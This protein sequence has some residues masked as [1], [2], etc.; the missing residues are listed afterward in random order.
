[1]QEI[2]VCFILRASDARIGYQ[3]N[4][5]TI[6]N[7]RYKKSIKVLKLWID[8]TWNTE[9]GII[10][11]NMIYIIGY[12]L[13]TKNLLL[14]FRARRQVRVKVHR[15]VARW[16]EERWQPGPALRDWAKMLQVN[17]TRAQ[18]TPR[19]LIWCE[20]LSCEQ[21]TTITTSTTWT[22]IT[23]AE[24]PT[25]TITRWAR[26]M[27]DQVHYNKIV[28]IPTWFFQEYKIHLGWK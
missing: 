14:D 23:E 3:W 16:A 19:A 9:N 22:T 2:I 15:L 24:P 18:T 7:T 13:L 28:K 8:L 26:M 25:T 11:W 20:R 1:M 17:S 5:M 21:Q 6:S 4:K 10:N 12:I 27:S